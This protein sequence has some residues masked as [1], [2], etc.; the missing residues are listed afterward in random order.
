MLF[1]IHDGTEAVSISK[2]IV[3]ILFRL[4]CLPVP[5]VWTYVTLGVQK[6]KTWRIVL[7]GIDT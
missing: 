7:C 1:Y 2:T 6:S 4:L 5:A 3:T